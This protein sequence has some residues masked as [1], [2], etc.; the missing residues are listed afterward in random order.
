LVI[1]S[2][3]ALLSALR[4][5]NDRTYRVQPGERAELGP[6][7]GPFEDGLAGMLDLAERVSRTSSR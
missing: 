7:D 2:S 5:V 6:S 4:E 3:F 1:G